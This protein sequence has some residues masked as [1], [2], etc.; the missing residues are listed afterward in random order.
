MKKTKTTRLTPH[1]RMDILSQLEVAQFKRGN[2]DDSLYD[3]F[4][5]CA[6]AVLNVDSLTDDAR[7][8]LRQQRL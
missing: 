7:E 8:V 5:R 2:Q 6:L 1:G 4:R 3:T